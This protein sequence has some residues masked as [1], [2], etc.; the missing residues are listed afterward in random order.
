MRRHPQVLTGPPGGVANRVARAHADSWLRA[1]PTLLVPVALAGVLAACATN[2][3][4]TPPRPSIG[5]KLVPTGGSAMGGGVAF[6]EV[7]G[8][9]MIAANV[10]N[11]TPGAWR[12]AIH[13]N[14]NC[15]SPNGFSAGPPILLP[16]SSLPAVVGLSLNENGIGGISTRLP[17][18]M[19]DGPNGIVGKSVV[20]HAGAIGS[21]E[22]VP[23]APNNRAA[24]GV[25]GPVVSLF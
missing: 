12:V 16:G 19:L 20:V 1:L 4:S 8:G 7:D 3:A 25:I 10:T 21:L 24:C 15:S 9:L 2:T 18:L 13:A 17:G 23:G 22:A 14:G 6:R 5:A 11:G